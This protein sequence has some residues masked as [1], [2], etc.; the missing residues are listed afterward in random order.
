MIITT[1]QLK[2]IAGAGGSV[3]LDASTMT[4]HQLREIIAAIAAGNAQ[5]T[6]HNLSGLTAGQLCEMAALAPRLITFDL[7]S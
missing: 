3:V 7:T 5:I 6:L 2:Q 4:F 1:E